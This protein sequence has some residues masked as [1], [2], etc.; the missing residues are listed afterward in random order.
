[1]SKPRRSETAPS[2]FLRDFI[3]HTAGLLDEWGN[4][5][6]RQQAL[7]VAARLL[8]MAEAPCEDA[9][10]PL[11]P[12]AYAKAVV[13]LAQQ[14]GGAMQYRVAP[15]HIRFTCTICRDEGGQTEPLCHLWW[16]SL[17]RIAAER[18]GYGKVV[19]TPRDA[20]ARAGC[21]V[22]LYLQPTAGAETSATGPVAV[23]RPAQGGPAPEP[24][25]QPERFSEATVRQLQAKVRY[26]EQ[27]TRE[28]ET[29]L[30][31][32]KL[33]EKAKGILMERLRLSEADAMRKLQQESQARNLKLAA[34]AQIIVQAGEML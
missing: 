3:G 24:G 5:Q 29:A 34:V 15:D 14:L 18:F 12:D 13:R 21:D 9:P 19:V 17:R 22:R 1:M 33:V 8:R 28:L 25:G 2:G 27:R 32:R 23:D 31:E 30:E 6:G 7:R 10:S 26:L 4:S 16:E 20:A 11:T